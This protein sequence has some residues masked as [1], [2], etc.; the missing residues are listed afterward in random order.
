MMTILS[1][2]LKFY[3]PKTFYFALA[4]C[5]LKKVKNIFLAGFEVIKIIKGKD[6]MNKIFIKF[7]NKKKFVKK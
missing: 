2:V 7:N 3:Y 4:I 6:E 1:Q 5:D